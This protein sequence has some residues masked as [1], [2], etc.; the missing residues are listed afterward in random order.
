MN[1]DLIE[2]VSIAA[3]LSAILMAGSTHLSMNIALYSLQT[4]LLSLAT[5]SLAGLR[6]E[7]HF[8]W[9]ALAIVV[10]KALGIPLFLHWI[11]VKIGVNSDPGTTLAPPLAMHCCVL[12]M[13]L[14]YF[15]AQSLPSSSLEGHSWANATAA[16]SLLLSG[17]ILMLTRRIALSQII[18]FLVIEN[19]IYL[20][21]LTQTSG[22]PLVVEMG[23][24]LDVLVGVMISG[25]LVFRI[26]RSFEHIDV[27]QLTEL[28]D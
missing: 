7:S 25:L 13:G 18:G 6:A 17:L 1:L 26:Q 11:M 19:G 27:T 9:V 21:A 20:F 24:L 23:V 16:I 8:I 15:L 4:F 22:M 2:L 3:A 5:Y 14:S 10:L 28:R 12:L